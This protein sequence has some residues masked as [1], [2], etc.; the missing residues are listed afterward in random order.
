MRQQIQQ[1]SPEMAFGAAVT[2]TSVGRR[3][4]CTRRQVGATTAAGPPDYFEQSF[5]PVSR[6][7]CSRDYFAARASPLKRC[8]DMNPINA[9]K[10]FELLARWDTLCCSSTHCLGSDTF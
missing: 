4:N 6:R 1:F 3:N 8:F 9:E 5:A 10:Y 2:L 7:P